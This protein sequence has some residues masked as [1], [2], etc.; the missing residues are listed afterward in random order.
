MIPLTLR[1]LFFLLA[2]F[3]TAHAGDTRV[4]SGRLVLPADGA[5]MRRTNFSK[6][7]VSAS[8]PERWFKI[9][10]PSPSV[11]NVTVTGPFFVPKNGVSGKS[12]ALKALTADVACELRDAN[13]QIIASSD[14]GG[15]AA[16]F[17]RRVPLAA[18][19]YF[20]RVAYVGPALT[21]LPSTETKFLVLVSAGADWDVIENSGE[22]LASHEAHHVGLLPLP[23]RGP[24]VSGRAT[25]I[26]T[27]GRSD[28]PGSRGEGPG[29]FFQIAKA[30]ERRDPAAQQALLD[31]TTAAAPQA[32]FDLSEG[33]WF[34]KI[35][36][37]LGERLAAGGRF[38]GA[39]LGAV[40]HSWGAYVNYE[41]AR[42]IAAAFSAGGMNRLIALD[43]ALVADNYDVTTAD[44]GVAA[45]Y[46]FAC[47][48]SIFGNES[49]AQTADDAFKIDL[50]ET[51]DPF[52]EH[53]AAHFL[54]RDLLDQADAISTALRGAV[55]NGGSALW[56]RNPGASGLGYD[57]KLNAA[58]QQVAI[59]PAEAVQD[60]E[61][62][63][64]IRN[65][66]GRWVPSRLRFAA[67]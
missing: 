23:G 46:S 34:S 6:A 18:G 54:F 55:L 13:D 31:W 35:G 53:N 22:L 8:E 3:A 36:V 33:R 51:S 44:F 62:T 14:H 20:L 9:R 60:Y 1:A 50:P 63:L 2:L 64:V 30:L 67:P 43:P 4:L 15:S 52:L 27:H 41:I 7:T 10:A 29:T 28:E 45:A 24:L 61:G 65:L 40:G 11:V 21:P 42:A 48:T 37:A 39:Q 59:T 49:V 19:S 38:G 12:S 47:S 32:A 25:W 57:R 17:L 26:T 58:G 5:S 56:Q 66:G 16:E